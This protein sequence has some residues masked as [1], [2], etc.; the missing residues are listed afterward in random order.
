MPLKV[1]CAGCSKDEKEQAEASVRKALGKVPP[2]ES[3]MV[4]LVKVANRWQVTLNGPPDKARSLTVLAPENRLRESIVEALERGP[5]A[6]NP[7]P[8]PAA[9]APPAWP[10][11]VA[12]VSGGTN[13]HQCGKCGKPFAVVFETRPGEP[14]QDAP[15]A[16]PHCWALNHVPIAAEAAFTRD[17]R[18]EKIGS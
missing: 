5:E 7:R 4:S 15:V 6:A 16:C 2:T 18:A 12:T 14:M 10:G 3:W 13:R 9:S 8:G 1:L 17:Y 11:S